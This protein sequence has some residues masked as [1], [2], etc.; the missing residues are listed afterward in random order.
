MR[1]LRDF[2][3]GEWLVRPSLDR[4][5]CSGSSVHLRPK[6]MDVLVYL[7]E[8]AGDV[9]PKDE[10]IAAVWQQK[11]LAESVLT[12]SIA[13]LR[14]ALGDRLEA[15][16]Y[17]ETITKRGYR[18]LA[19]VARLD[20]PRRAATGGRGALVVS[21]AGRRI[22]LAEGES[23]IGRAP[24]ATVRIDSMSVSRA[25]ARIVV[26]N[27]HVHLEDLGSKNGTLVDGIAVQGSADLTDGAR[28]KIGS[29]LL[30]L[31]V[32]GLAGSTETDRTGATDAEVQGPSSDAG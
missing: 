31:H 2:R 4:M 6:L 15:P 5:E 23:M 26:S 1:A 8:H 11:Y 25:H 17:I 7:A 14:R 22:A 20:A 16:R 19:A 30:V 32:I 12:R 3:L 13:E 27:G 21:Y 18:L 9:V 29:A 28:I 24:D 10:I